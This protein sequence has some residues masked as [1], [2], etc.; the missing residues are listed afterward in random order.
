MSVITVASADTGT[1]A[2]GAATTELAQPACAGDPV[3][4]GSIT[5]ARQA[6]T[7]TLDPLHIR[8]GNGDIFADGLI[9]QGLVQYDPTGKTD[10][11]GGVAESWTVSPD[12]LTYTFKLRPGIKFS[13]GQP[14]TA[15]DVKFSLDQFGDPK[16]NE[17]MS[18]LTTGYEASTI[19]DPSTFQVNLSTPVPSFL[20][21]I[22]TFAASI[23]PK[24][25]VQKQGDDF[26]NHPVGTGP[27]MV[28]DF[29]SGSHV[30]FVRNPNYW[31][32]GKPYLDKVTFNFAIDGNSRLLS[33]TSGDVQVADGIAPSQI[34][35][36]RGDSNLV[37]KSFAIP[38]WIQIF[39]NHNKPELADQ[40]VRLAIMSALDLKAINDQIF[41]GLGIIPNSVLPQL[42]YDAPADVIAPFTFDLDKAKALMAKSAYPSGFSVKLE[43]PS[44]IDYFNQLGLL[45]QQQLSKIGIKV[46][47][48]KEDPSALLDNW[49][50]EKYD[51]NFAFP[52]ITSDVAVPDE[53]ALFFGDPA[54]NHG[55]HTNF[56]DPA[57]TKLIKAFV[58]NPDDASR[59]KQ[60][61]VIQQT[62]ID[63]QP[64]F[65][66]LDVPLL[67]A[68][69]TNV[70]GTDVNALGIDQL[71][72]TWLA[73]S[74]G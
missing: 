66:I 30:T 48:L 20:D 45:I 65:N 24:D 36:V 19:V 17:V 2:T 16:I 46:E 8:N 51:L 74:A 42:K 43:Y 72:N 67:N 57:L 33:L 12:G 53:F 55:F 47:L 23:L 11:I 68:Y 32:T 15:D 64:M 56:S 69:A 4:G 14:V 3:T 62:F 26:W 25:L 13:N 1:V 21:N 63:Q 35:A 73:P 7:Q 38:A 34:E 28:S 60:W 52:V 41:G 18:I 44:G 39:P 49:R 70:C 54:G 9:Y 40:N 37:L 61:P 5:Y 10:I 22:S 59:A 50:G 58:S 6:E 29:V 27:F 31:D 71:Q